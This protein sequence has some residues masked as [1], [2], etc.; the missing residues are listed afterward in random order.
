M[1]PPTV[2]TLTSYGTAVRPLD[3]SRRSYR[4]RG[5]LQAAR[6]TAV[7]A[8]TRCTAVHFTVDTAVTRPHAHVAAAVSIFIF[9][10]MCDFE[11]TERLAHSVR[12]RTLRRAHSYHQSSARP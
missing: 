6:T 5:R 11:I 7:A 2:R 1:S 8:A 12:Q 10:D 9:Q 3:E 4:R